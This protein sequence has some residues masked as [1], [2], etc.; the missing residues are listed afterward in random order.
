M[1][2]N[3]YQEAIQNSACAF[4]YHEAVFDENNKMTDYIFIDINQSFEKM[5]GLKRE[6][7]IN[8]R[9]VRDVARDKDHA[10][11]CVNIYEKVIFEKI[12]IE[13]EEHS[14]EYRKH[15]SVIAYPAENNRF[16]TLF[17]NITFEKKML[18]I[19]KYFIDN[20]GNHIDYDKITDFAYD[21]SGAEYAAFN[22][23]DKKRKNFT[24]VSLRGASDRIKK[25]LDSL[26][27]EVVGKTW[28]YN[29]A[30]NEKTKDKDILSFETLHDLIKD[31]I[32]KTIVMQLEK[33]LGIDNTVVAIITKEDRM[34]G[35]FTLLFKKGDKLINRDLFR[36]YLS[37][38]GLFIEKTRFEQSLMTSQNRFFTLAEYA[39]VGFISCNTRGEIT[40][41][42]KKI[43]EI[44]GS[45]SYEATKSFNLL[46]LPSLK[47]R[48]FSNKLLECMDEDRE[49]T[50]EM[51]YKSIWGKNNWLRLH[52]SP[53]NKNGRVI[54]ANIVVD[55]ITDKKMHEDALKE[56][57]RRDPL[58][59]AYNR[60]ALE[61]VLLNRLNEANDKQF[62][63]C[64]AIVDVDNLKNI[65]D[66]YGHEAG[67]SVL[68]YLATRVKQEI[69]E[70]DLIVRTGGDEFLI[71]LHDIEDKKNASYFVKRIFEK[72][73]TKYRFRD[74]ANNNRFSL[75]VGCSIGVSFFPKDGETVK[76]LMA[77]ADIALYKVKNSGKSNYNI[78]L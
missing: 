8:K 62:I 20:M 27:I 54:G 3:I 77:K 5:T 67:D 55:D 15:Y 9:F 70:R 25:E 14:K 45:P 58:T 10:L 35:N 46:E 69:R 24:T 26:N 52:Y 76:E 57:A 6:N 42:N 21:V 60:L 65:N 11:E 36:L 19:A 40:Y 13:F 72:I 22:L 30:K 44:M 75:D 39:P 32:S 64:I 71:Y 28:P 1:K 51:G 34:L 63:S 38:L 48:G 17:L 37:Q 74:D 78:E 56:K 2:I 43:L 66:T 4:A 59:R 50:Y 73:S 31:T 23:F 41:A 61:T 29:P 68:K 53:Y 33:V 7:I 16:V 47:E 49:I 12:L 18:E